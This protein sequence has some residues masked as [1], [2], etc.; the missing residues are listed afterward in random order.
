MP[1]WS[2]R[3]SPDVAGLRCGLVLPAMSNERPSARPLTIE[4]LEAGLDVLSMEG[5]D[6]N[7]FWSEN[8]EA[9]RRTV[10]LAIRDTSDALLSPTIPLRWRLRF[11]RQLEELIQYLELA[12]RYIARRPLNCERQVVQRPPRPR[13]H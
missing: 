2:Y 6:L 1:V 8:V 10:L 7:A 4:Q 11:E 5:T 3:M 13:A 9:F 12:G